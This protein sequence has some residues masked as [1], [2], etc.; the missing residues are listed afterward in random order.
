MLPLGFIIFPYLIFLISSFSYQKSLIK[1]FFCGISFGFGFLLIYLSWI[2]NPFLIYETTKPYSF[3]AILL[4]IFLSIFFGLGFL[5]YKF[6]KN[7]LLIILTTP[8][9]FILIELI[10]SNFIYGFPWISNSL[11]L[12]NNSLGFYLI[13]YF[14]TN[15]SGYLILSI[16]LIMNLLFYNNKN[17]YFRKLVFLAYAPFLFFFIIPFINLFFNEDNLNKQINIDAY[18]I[19]SPIEKNNKE[20]ILADIID[21][22]NNSKSDYVIFGENNFPNLIDRNNTHNLEAINT[23][24]KKVIIG[25]TSFKDNTFYNSFLLLQ[26]DKISFF[27]KKIL[28]PFGE[29]LPFRKYF[30]FMEKIS[31]NVD[32]EKGKLDRIINTNDN[33]KILPIICYEIIFD[34]IFNNIDKKNIDIMINITNDSWFGDKIGPYQHFYI[35]RIKTLIANKPLIRVSNNGISAIIDQNAKIINYS[36]LNE[37]NNL[38]NKL[39]ISTNKSF[40]YFH[41]LHTLYLFFIF[42]FIIFT[43]INRRNEK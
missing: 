6:L 16:F 43:H 5:I 40:L 17:S 42:G 39:I 23:N 11:I 7:P 3:I 27:D 41:K 2:Y 1:L 21:I 22:I 24:D 8:L 13:K 36:N 30:K 28:V 15:T 35:T 34:K 37:I 14:G 10:I 31:G 12:S 4:P 20:K 26:D 32:F 25:A 29:F 9:I 19:L 33:L 18:Q 38:K